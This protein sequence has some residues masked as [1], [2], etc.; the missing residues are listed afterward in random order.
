MLQI[1]GATAEVE[2]TLIQ[3]QA[4][5]GLR[6]GRAKRKRP[7]TLRKQNTTKIVTVC[8]GGAPSKAFANELGLSVSMLYA[9]YSENPAQTVG[10]SLWS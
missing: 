5:A 1:I 2:R 6:N 9:A 8:N 10:V 4:K 3:E 7:G